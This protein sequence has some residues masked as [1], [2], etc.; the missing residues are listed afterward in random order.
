MWLKRHILTA[1]VFH[2]Q[3]SNTGSQGDSSRETLVFVTH[4]TTL[5]CLFM[6]LGVHSS[7]GLQS[8]LQGAEIMNE[9]HAH[10]ISGRIWSPLVY[11]IQSV[12]SEL[13]HTV[14]ICVSLYLK[15]KLTVLK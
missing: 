7:Y 3:K 6:F 8:V 15:R 4:A 13:L 11:L 1:S 5:I 10:Q 9:T 14:R 12:K 2:T